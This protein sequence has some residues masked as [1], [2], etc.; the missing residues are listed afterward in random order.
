MPDDDPAPK[1]LT[2]A[3]AAVDAVCDA[4]AWP[5]QLKAGHAASWAK[6]TR[7]ALGLE[8]AEFI[9]EFTRHYGRRDPGVG[10]WWAYRELYPLN[11][12]AGT[13]PTPQ[14]VTSTWGRW[15]LPIAV[16]LPAGPAAQ[17]VA[18]AQELRRGDTDRS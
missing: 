18:Y 9:A 13:F 5:Y 11:K 16:V 7:T 1:L 14:M 3:Q 12:V 6:R 2:P 15:D 10:E 4:F 17:M 8:L